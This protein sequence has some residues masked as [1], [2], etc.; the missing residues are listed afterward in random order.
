[1]TGENAQQAKQA[2]LA[3]SIFSYRI[4]KS[5]AS[6]SA[7]LEQ[8]DGIIF[9]GGIGENSAL[10]R[11]MVLAQLSL[12]NFTIDP[13]KNQATRQG[14]CDNIASSNSRAC[15]VIPTNEEYVIARQTEQLIT[16]PLI[17]Q[18]SKD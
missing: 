1:M 5:I 13:V 10:V 8:L 7:A 4:A 9:T 11:E 18:E 3:L 2:K 15:W 14:V 6:F 12:L 16:Q 17:Q